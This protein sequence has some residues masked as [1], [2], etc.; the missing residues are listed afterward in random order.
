MW[1]MRKS[2]KTN[3]VKCFDDLWTT[4]Y[5]VQQTFLTAT[6]TF[7]RKLLISY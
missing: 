5:N 2:S 4:A 7:H 1:F 6:E 3:K